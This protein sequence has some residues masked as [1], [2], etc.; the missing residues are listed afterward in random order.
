MGD[1]INSR[2]IDEEMRNIVK[3]TAVNAFKRINT[4]Y[5]DKL[6]APFGLVRGDA[7]EGV[8]LTQ[9]NATQ[10][11]QDIIKT[12]YSANKTAVR[13]CV[14]LGELTVTSHDRNETDGPAFH[15][16]LDI[17]E[18][19][20][21]K[22]SKHWLQVSFDVGVYGKPLIDSNLTLLSA[23]TEQWTDKQREIA[24]AIE[25]HNN[26]QKAVAELFGV[27]SSVV[28]RQLK[29]AKYDVYRQAWNSLAEH[30]VMIDEFTVTQNVQ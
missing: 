17:L 4:D 15:K 25:E 11:V 28:N 20:K 5:N 2:D 29:A 30:L 21:K 26:S 8:L 24:W 1:I 10:V 9:H 23:L 7:F 14:V 27:A 19:I 16:A 12:F 13:I 18:E 6:M 22:R 3:Q